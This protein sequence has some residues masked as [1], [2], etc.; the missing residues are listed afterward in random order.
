MSQSRGL[1]WAVAYLAVAGALLWPAAINGRPAYFFDSAGYY[2]NGRA[3]VAAVE[4]KLAPPRPAAPSAGATQ[5]DPAKP[6]AHPGGVVAIRAV[7]YAVFAYLGGWP[8]GRMVAVILLQALAASA[9]LMI[10][11]RRMDPN[12]GR[13]AAVGAGLL[14]AAGSSASWFTSFVMPDIFAGLNP[15]LEGL[16]IDGDDP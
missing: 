13:T 1:G 14:I 8:S 9:V 4:A 7:A 6:A 2:A 11:W 12:V 5:A 16:V 3:V 10:W 15:P